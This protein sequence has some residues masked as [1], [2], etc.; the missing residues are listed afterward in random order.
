V[1]PALRIAVIEADDA[2]REL[3]LRWLAA[4]GHAASGAARPVP[5][6]IGVA[7]VVAD[8]AQPRSAAALA[9]L[10]E[11]TRPARLV[12]VSARF[13]RADTLSAPLAHQLG[14][15][16]VLAKPYTGD[17]LLAAVSAGLRGPSTD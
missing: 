2:I 6:P 17:E 1:D 5:P 10:R 14:V 7:L 4:A 9:R 16:A 12:L 3:A 11:A 13:R 15:A 8:L